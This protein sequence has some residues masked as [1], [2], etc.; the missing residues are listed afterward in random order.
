M[1]A[2][3]KEGLARLEREHLERASASLAASGAHTA[4][5]AKRSQWDS[6]GLLH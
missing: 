2:L 3:A 6:G 4:S 1:R 5:V